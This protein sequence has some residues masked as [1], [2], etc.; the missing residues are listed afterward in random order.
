MTAAQLTIA[1]FAALGATVVALAAAIAYARR[2]R[3]RAHVTSVGVM[4][5][6]LLA[7]LLAAETLG[8]RFEF[9]E[10]AHAVHM[11]IAY[12]TAGLLVLPLLSGALHWRGRVSRKVH[13]AAVAVWLAA[14]VAALGSGL[15]MFSG[16]TEREPAAEV[17]HLAGSE[18][19]RPK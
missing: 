14:L 11:P 19:P 2:H 8:R 7:T 15:W 5:V 17:G 12:A 1:F 3:V 13:V 18:A 10:G 9:D 6:C 4:L 16:A